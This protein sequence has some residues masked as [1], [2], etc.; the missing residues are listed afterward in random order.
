MSTTRVLT[1]VSVILILSVMF[2]CLFALASVNLALAQQH[3]HS[4]KITENGNA[5]LEFLRIGTSPP[6]ETLYR[7][8]SALTASLSAPPDLKPPCRENYPCGVPG[9]LLVTQSR[10]GSFESIEDMARGV[11]ESAVVSA[12]V[13]KEIVNSTSGTYSFDASEINL[14]A[15][16]ASVQLHIVVLK[17]SSIKSLKDLQNRSIAVGISGSA[18]ALQLR[19]AMLV[20]GENFDATLT[21]DLPLHEALDKL[22][23]RQIDA[24]AITAQAPMPILQNFARKN[25]MRLLDLKNLKAKNSN[26]LNTQNNQNNQNSQK[27]GQQKQDA[28]QPTILPAKTYIGQEK[29]INTLEFNIW[30]VVSKKLDSE[31]VYRI[32]KAL[33]H[34]STQNMVRQLVPEARIQKPRALKLISSML[35]IHPGAARWYREKG[36]LAL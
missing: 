35:T 13:L 31:S 27:Q 12:D 28:P 6:D 3:Q 34:N 16:L 4:E 14:L 15:H 2:G 29:D 10:T 1:R 17:E 36:L 30:W 18:Y 21:L 26:I 9:L 33:W 20:L 11:L 8:G 7:L 32:T 19:Q 22:A 24:I 23:Q 5:K 25:P